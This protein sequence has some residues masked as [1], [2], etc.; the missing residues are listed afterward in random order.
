[1]SATRSRRT[2]RREVFLNGG[3]LLFGVLLLP[4]AVY[5]VGQVV[6]GQYEGDGIGEFFMS[7][8]GRLS[9]GDFAAWFL[10]LSPLLI[11]LVLRPR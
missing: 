10:V 2:V 5:L 4:L 9:G 1:M 8:L 7:L 11:V 3:L 6:F